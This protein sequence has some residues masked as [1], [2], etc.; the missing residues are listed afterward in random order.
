MGIISENLKVIWQRIEKACLRS[1]RNT[2]EITLIAVSK[3][4]PAEFVI[5]AYEHGIINFGENRVQEAREKLEKLTG[6]RDKTVW[7][8]IGRLQTNKAKTAST[9]FDMIQSIDSIKLAEMINKMS[10]KPTP[11]LLEINVSGE[12]AKTGFSIADMPDTIHQMEK[13]KNITLS[14]FMT[15][16]PIVKNPEEARPLF[17]QLSQLKK[18]FNLPHLSMGMT[19]D[20]EIAIEEG[21]TMVRIGRAIFGERRYT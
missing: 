13:L 17:Q 2:D 16:A 20:F 19:D 4:M 11:V 9:L 21:A 3:N 8:M 10:V 5:E 1:R 6:I 14:G 12:A 7:H 15:V 18:E